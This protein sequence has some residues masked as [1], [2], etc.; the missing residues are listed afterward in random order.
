MLSTGSLDPMPLSHRRAD[1]ECSSV[2][3]NK[4]CSDGVFRVLHK[5]EVMLSSLL[6]PVS[7]IVNVFVSA[8]G[9]FKVVCSPVLA[10]VVLPQG[11]IKVLYRGEMILWSLFIPIVRFAH[12][13]LGFVK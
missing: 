4:Y 12:V 3:F 5:G 7:I 13:I 10:R 2:V 9:D 6:T 11:I 1:G 8:I